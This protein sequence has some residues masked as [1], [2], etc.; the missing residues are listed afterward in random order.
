[1][2][3]L[4]RTNNNIAL[5]F[6]F[7]ENGYKSI[8]VL[9]LSYNLIFWVGLHAFSGLEKLVH[10]DLSSNRLRFIP[11]D[12]FFDT[13]EL[14]TLDISSNIFESLKNEPFIMHAKLEVCNIILLKILRKQ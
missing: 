7:Q 14:K 2:H 5:L 9:D 11:S 13:P 1:M 8:E 4:F 6:F 10:I 3:L 12:I